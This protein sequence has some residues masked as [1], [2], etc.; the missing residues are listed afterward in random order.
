MSVNEV[1][2]LGPLST[3]QFP[4][5]IDHFYLKR[6]TPLLILRST[7]R[8]FYVNNSIADSKD[9][10]TISWYHNFI[11]IHME[12]PFLKDWLNIYKHSAGYCFRM[13]SV[14]WRVVLLRLLKLQLTGNMNLFNRIDLEHKM[15]H[16]FQHFHAL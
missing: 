3:A 11:G 5:S 8:R 2:I 7:Q 1:C 16:N 10:A 12:R 6:K 4:K 15:L 9:N 13:P 14:F